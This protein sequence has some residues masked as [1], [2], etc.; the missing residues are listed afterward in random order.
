MISYEKEQKKTGVLHVEPT[1][2]V[3]DSTETGAIVEFKVKPSI[4]NRRFRE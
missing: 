4:H 3:N 1:T 2:A